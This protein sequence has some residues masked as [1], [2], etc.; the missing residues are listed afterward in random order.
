M[1]VSHPFWRAALVSASGAFHGPLRVS[2]V[3]SP[4][5]CRGGTRAHSSPPQ[6]WRLT[7]PARGALPRPGL[8][9]G[10]RR[11]S[12]PTA[13][14]RPWPVFPFTHILFVSHLHMCTRIHTFSHPH[15]CA[16]TPCSLPVGPCKGS[17]VATSW[18]SMDWRG[19][20]L[21]LAR[22]VQSPLPQ[23]EL[24]RGLRSAPS[25]VGSFLLR[26][27]VPPRLS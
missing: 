19:W 15:V 25:S 27:L 5:C 4:G 2:T 3:G 1:R 9:W 24:G 21:A 16:H 6:T 11:G 18:V 20:R 12:G 23:P 26:A 17:W 7:P 14:K 10:G 8:S 22:L 13:L